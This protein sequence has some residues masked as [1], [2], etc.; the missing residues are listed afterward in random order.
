MPI[1]SLF[2]TSPQPPDNQGDDDFEVL[3]IHSSSSEDSEDFD[4]EEQP[5]QSSSQF[6][7]DF[8][9]EDQQV[10][11]SDRALQLSI[12]SDLGDDPPVHSS[13]QLVQSGMTLQ[14]QD[15]EGLYEKDSDTPLQ[16]GGHVEEQQVH[17]SNLNAQSLQGANHVQSSVNAPPLQDAEDHDDQPV[18][19]SPG[20]KAEQLSC[21]SWEWNTDI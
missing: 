8:V 15:E 2:P 21:S 17:Q 1:S 19:Y 11:S 9:L 7:E 18:I 12:E 14:L 16:D 10:E 5:I 20:I 13:D 3:S 4:M 6:S